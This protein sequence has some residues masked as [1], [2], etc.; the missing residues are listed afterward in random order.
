MLEARP[1]CTHAVAEFSGRLQDVLTTPEECRVS[2]SARPVAE[3][4]GHGGVGEHI[5]RDFLECAEG[6]SA[7]RDRV[8]VKACSPVLLASSDVGSG[9]ASR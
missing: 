3:K 2:E 7:R 6:R 8:R 9:R 1:A 4:R 5:R